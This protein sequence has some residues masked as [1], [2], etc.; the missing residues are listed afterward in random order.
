MT[1]ERRPD[2]DVSP[3]PEPTREPART[4]AARPP[5]PGTAGGY[6]GAL[7]PRDDMLAAPWLAIVITIFVMMFVLAFLDVPSRFF[8]EE[9]PPPVTPAPTLDI[10]PEPSPEAS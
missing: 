7:A 4:D 9:V 8:A 10:S 5:R 1:D 3:E 2:E 6:R